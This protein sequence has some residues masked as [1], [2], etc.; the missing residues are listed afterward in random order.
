M[1]EPAVSS[2]RVPTFAEAFRFWLRLGFISFGGPA[3]QIAIMHQ[4]LVERRR[5]VDEERFQHALNYCMLL[6]G[7]E[8]QQLATYLGWLF[9]G[10]R[11]G[12]VAGTLFF[13]PAAVLLWCLSWLYVTQG[14]IA[15]VAGIF[16]GIKPAV[17]AIVAAAMIRLG[18]KSLT[19]SLR[20]TLAGAAFALLEFTHTPFPVVVFGAGLIGWFGAAK[21]E[22]R[23][24]KRESSEP[25]SRFN[26]LN[27]A[28]VWLAVWWLPLLA[29]GMALGWKHTAFREALFFSRAALVT[30]G[31]A[32]AVLP[33]VQT[34]A[35]GHFGWLTPT[36]FLDGL[37]LGETT[38]G[39]L[40]IVLQW[41]GFLGGWHRPGV[42][43]PLASA[44]LGAMATT[45]ATFAPSFLWI[46]TG[47]PLIERLRH[48]ND[49]TAA[50]G[51]VTAAVVGVIATLAVQLGRHVARPAGAGL[52]T[53]AVILALAVFIGLVWTKLRPITAIVA[54]GMLGSLWK[55]V[56]G[57]IH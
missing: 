24:P 21:D 4:E 54:C 5:W 19:N 7:P 14:Q 20:W 33:Y 47:A 52:D 44:T 10:W 51:A 18:R 30:F 43:S 32:Y 53:I 35:V 25:I 15:W 31:G 57:G 6:P 13:L 48:R 28:L 41:V 42:L 8:A 40:V 17:V 3:G 1:T 39:P 9:H 50:L 22:V 45:W 11:G 26:L 23:S 46:F 29:L 2:V 38:P 37:A 34:Q 36:Q 49:L 55:L 56:V 12:V 16:Y 27:S